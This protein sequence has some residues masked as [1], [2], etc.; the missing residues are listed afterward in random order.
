[1]G[2]HS[3]FTQEIADKICDQISEGKSLRTIC[4]PNKM[5][6]KGTVFKWLVE[7][8]SFSNQYAQARTES[9]NALFEEMLDICDTG[10]NDWMEQNATG[11]GR[12]AWKL[13][14]EH[15]QRSKLRVDTRKWALS[16]LQPKKFGERMTTEHTGNLA[17]TDMT[18]AQ[19]DAKI[20]EL[21]SKVERSTED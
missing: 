15:V 20:L 8:P 6:S 18:S 11:E 4:K 1:M 19:L 3:E 7:Y 12:K 5:V 14:G 9:T 10:A 13:N 16:K 17:L 2:R 21:E